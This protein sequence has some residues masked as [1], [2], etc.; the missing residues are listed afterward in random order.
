MI[1]QNILYMKYM[2]LFQY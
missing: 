1:K 2:I